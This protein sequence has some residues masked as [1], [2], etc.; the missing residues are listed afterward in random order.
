MNEGLE[1]INSGAFGSSKLTKLIIPKSVTYI[2]GDAFDYSSY[3]VCSNIVFYCRAS[4]MPGGWQSGWN[5][6]RPI[7]WG[8][9]ESTYSDPTYTFE[10]NG[11]TAVSSM[12]QTQILAA[13]V[14]TKTG[15]V[16]AGWYDNASFSGNAVSFPYYSASKTTLYAKFVTESEYYNGTS[17]D[18]AI[19]ITAGSSETVVIDTAGERVYYKF[20][21][22]ETK[23]Y[24]IRSQGGLD[25]YGY[26]Y[27]S[28][29]SQIKYNDGTSDFTITY[30]LTAGST[31]YIAVE[32]YR[33]SATGTFTLT[34]S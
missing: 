20:T 27:N 14:S 28:S 17:F 6:G 34:V 25:T 32:L 4:V 30:T 13:P 2:S 21:P 1:E 22:T 18:W 23:S 24:T 26:L 31:Y 29:K 7:I 3:G 15:Y 33:S 11:G 8:Y 16:L 10:T 19:P 9:D 5:F 12:T